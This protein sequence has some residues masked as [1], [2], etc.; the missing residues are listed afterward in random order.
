MNYIKIPFSEMKSEFK[1][2]LLSHKLQQTV[3]REFT[4]M[5][6]IVF[7]GLLNTLKTDTLMLLPSLN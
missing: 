2:I 6:F 3:L 1:R 5:E 4:H 7:Q